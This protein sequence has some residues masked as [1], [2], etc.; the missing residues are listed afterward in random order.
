MP[1]MQTKTQKKIALSTF[2]ACLAIVEHI[3]MI[4]VRIFSNCCNSYC[5]RIN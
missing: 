1:K 5:A 3:L 4:Q 2:A